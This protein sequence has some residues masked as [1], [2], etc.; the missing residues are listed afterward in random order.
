MDRD[1]VVGGSG[2]PGEHGGLARRGLGQVVLELLQEADVRVHASTSVVS[3]IPRS[4]SISGH[5]P[6]PPAHA[7]AG[8][9]LAAAE[10]IGDLGVGEFVDHAQLHRVALVGAQGLQGLGQRLADRREIDQVLDPFVVLGRKLP[11]GHPD[12]TASARVDPSVP[13]EASQPVSSDAVDPRH[14]VH[15]LVGVGLPRGEGLGEGLGR[16]LG[17]RLRIQRAAREVAEQVFGVSP[18]QLGE[19]VRFVPGCEQELGIGALVRHGCPFVGGPRGSVLHPH[20]ARRIRRD[21]PVGRPGT[22]TRFP[23]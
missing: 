22:L 15:P 20:A 18:I 14:A 12:A 11:F 16:Q 19:R 6:Q 8:V 5:L 1:L 13:E 23:P 7:L 2:G 21:R 17:R 4:C 3:C 9:G 10:P